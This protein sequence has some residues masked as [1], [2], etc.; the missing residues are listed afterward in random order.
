MRIMEVIKNHTGIMKQT[1]IGHKNV[2]LY[3]LIYIFFDASQT[4][5]NIS[6]FYQHHLNMYSSLLTN[7]L[8]KNNS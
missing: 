4:L 7:L 6:F 8:V 5:D 1:S 3:L 2:D